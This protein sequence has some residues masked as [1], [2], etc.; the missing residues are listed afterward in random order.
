[1]IARRRALAASIV[2]VLASCSLPGGTLITSTPRHT[3]FTGTFGADS[4]DCP[5]VDEPD[6]TRTYL[7][8]G[9]SRTVTG[10]SPFRLH[11]ATGPVA[12]EGD[13]I[14]VSGTMARRSAAPAYRSAA[15]RVELVGGG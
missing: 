14:E 1:M 13:V 8:L 3:V 5:F 4:V 7:M 2:L 11:S 9:P 15:D 6:G 10:T 12:E